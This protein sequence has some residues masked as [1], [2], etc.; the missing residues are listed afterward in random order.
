MRRVGVHW[1]GPIGHEQ[2]PQSSA[3]QDLGRQLGDRDAD[4]LADIGNR[5]RGARVG[6]QDKEIVPSD[7]HLD[8]D[9]SHRAHCLH[10]ACGGILNAGDQAG[11]EAHRWKDAG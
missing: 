3:D 10:Q 9:Q 2:L 5:A 8:V 7:G 6:L 1:E 4:G 11:R